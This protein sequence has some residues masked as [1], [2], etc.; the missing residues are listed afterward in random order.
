GQRP[1]GSGNPGEAPA[2]EAQ[3][4]RTKCAF[5]G[6]PDMV[7]LQG[8]RGRGPSQGSERDE[9]EAPRDHRSEGAP[10]RRRLGVAGQSAV[11]RLYAGR[12][13]RRLEYASRVG[14][15]SRSRSARAQPTSDPI[16]TSAAV[17]RSPTRNDLP[18]SER[19][20]TPAASPHSLRPCSAIAAERS[21]T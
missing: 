9:P 11:A 17:K 10:A 2:A 18:S 4:A 13:V 16:I 1:A 21:S 3:R 14:R 5:W 20:R 8:N 15:P 7:A 12:S 19:S 6:G